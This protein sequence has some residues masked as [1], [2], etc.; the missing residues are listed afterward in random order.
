MTWGSL[1]D[2]L[3]FVARSCFAPSVVVL[4]V[5][6]VFALD[7]A[8]S[9]L[10]ADIGRRPFGADL[11][12]CPPC[13]GLGLPFCLLCRPCRPSCSAVWCRSCVDPGWFRRPLLVPTRRLSGPCRPDKESSAYT[14]VLLL[15]FFRITLPDL[16]GRHVLSALWGRHTV[17]L[18]LADTLCRPF[19]AASILMI[20]VLSA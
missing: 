20:Y 9:A 3:G 6:V 1:L 10:E 2:T 8:L 14:D 4:L 7:L 11:G 13:V 12:F 17:S 16:Q 19:P 5:S 15:Q 18:S